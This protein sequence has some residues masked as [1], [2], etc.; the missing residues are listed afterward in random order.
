MHTLS[1]IWIYPVKSLGG[2]ALQE[3]KVEPRGLQYDRR[4]MLVDET[5]R[6]VSQREIPAMALLGTALEPPH[7][8]V[9]WKKNPSGKIKRANLGRQMPGAGAAERDKRLV[10]RKFETKPAARRHARNHPSLG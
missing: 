9:F 7:L 3:A 5:G 10:F 1:E 6:F 4:W 8:N 2:I